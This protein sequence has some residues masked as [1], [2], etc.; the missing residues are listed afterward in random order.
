MLAVAASGSPYALFAFPARSLDETQRALDA[1]LGV[2]PASAPPPRATPALA[3]L[4]RRARVRPAKEMSP[5]GDVL[6]AEADTLQACA[7]LTQIAGSLGHLFAARVGVAD[8]I[9]PTDLVSRYLSLPARIRRAGETM[10]I[11]IPGASLDVRR[12]GLDA[13]PGWVPWLRRRVTFDFEDDALMS[14]HVAREA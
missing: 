5:A 14:E 1:F 10:E 12:A 7:L 3:E 2:W 4:D 8:R 13:N 6:V 9:G 11:R